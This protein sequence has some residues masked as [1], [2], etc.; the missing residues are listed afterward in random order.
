MAKF[1]TKR[2]DTRKP[3]KKLVDECVNQDNNKI[4]NE[5]VMTTDEKV[6]MAQNVLKPASNTKRIKKDKGLIERTESSKTILTEDNKELL[7]D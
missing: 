2:I 1:I 7:V 6:A 5:V 3:Q 4:K